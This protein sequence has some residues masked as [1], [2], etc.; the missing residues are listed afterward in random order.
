MRRSHIILALAAAVGV[1][2]L[3]LADRI[4]DVMA[5]IRK[6][7]QPAEFTY[8]DK[9]SG[10]LCAGGAMT[11]PPP[12]GGELKTARGTPFHVRTPSNYRADVPHPL[13]VVFAPA[14]FSNT[15]NESMTRLTREATSQG[16]VLAYVA[17]A[18]LAMASYEDQAAI[19]SLVKQR[20]CIDDKRVFF[21]GHSNGG[22]ITNAMAFLPKIRGQAAAIA[23]SA[24]GI[25]GSNMSEFGCPKPTP[26]MVIHG[27]NDELFPGWGEDAAKWWAQCNKCEPK[28]SKS[29]KFPKCQEFVNC[30]E[31][32]PTYYCETDKRH[33]SW[34]GLNDTVLGFFKTQF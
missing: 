29:T 33:S 25:K 20:W 28:R 9:A 17:A 32:G 7:S 19:P 16:F 31:S 10:V 1:I 12:E 21:T 24:A 4:F 5:E 13:I 27:A 23:P 14:T 2:A 34:P 15:R 22:L 26:V 6:E 18:P 30:H 8:S 3:L 11:Q